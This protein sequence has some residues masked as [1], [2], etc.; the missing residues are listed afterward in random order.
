MTG[1]MGDVWFLIV[2]QA[3]WPFGAGY[4]N[5]LGRVHRDMEIGDV[6]WSRQGW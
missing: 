3:V 1:W 2:F 4:G 5:R 6:K